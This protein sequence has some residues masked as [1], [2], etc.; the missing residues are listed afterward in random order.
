MP[1][2]NAFKEMVNRGAWALPLPAEW[3]EDD[4]PEL[5][6]EPL[7]QLNAARDENARQVAIHA[8][9]GRS[10]MDEALKA[11]WTYA[12]VTRGTLWEHYMRAERLDGTPEF[13]DDCPKE[14]TSNKSTLARNQQTLSRKIAKLQK[15]LDG[16][17]ELSVPP[18]YLE[19][20]VFFLE[21][22]KARI[23]PMRAGRGRHLS[24][25]NLVRAQ[26]LERGLK[27]RQIARLELGWIPPVRMSEWRLRQKLTP[28]VFSNR[29]REIN[30]LRR[31]TNRRPS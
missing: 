2:W 19:P 9:G 15:Y 28:E 20:L 23:P 30:D 7:E 31:V 26:L 3:S 1:P 25:R 13:L 8:L 17:R 24:A 12:R 14:Q 4:A 16:L 22:H 5:G 11:L 27:A 6:A 21:F 18:S 29:A 10:K